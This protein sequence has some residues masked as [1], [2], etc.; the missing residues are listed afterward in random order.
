MSKKENK[1]RLKNVEFSINKNDADKSD[2]KTQFAGGSEIMK[3]YV[4]SLFNNDE[5]A[6][7]DI[8]SNANENTKHFR[9]S[10][11]EI[12]KIKQLDNKSFSP[13]S[14]RILTTKNSNIKAKIGL[15]G[16]RQIKRIDGVRYSLFAIITQVDDYPWQLKDARW[17]RI[18]TDIEQAGKL[19]SKE[20]VESA[21]EIAKIV[22]PDEKISSK[23]KEDLEKEFIRINEATFD[24][25]K[26]EDSSGSDSTLY[27]YKISPANESIVI[28]SFLFFDA[29]RKGDLDSKDI[30]FPIGL[31]SKLE[32]I[33][34]LCNLDNIEIE[35]IYSS[36]SFAIVITK[37]VQRNDNLPYQLGFTFL[38]S[39]G[40]WLFNDTDWISA[41]NRQKIIFR[42]SRE[43]LV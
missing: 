23:D 33:S 5:N 18:G 22:K 4:E 13:A 21:V 24:F 43:Y 3:T 30:T 19:L 31:K 42:M 1:F 40:R 17:Y 34:E 26:N 37:G 29:L 27:G 16:A 12:D 32:K 36:Q 38:C 41:E 6:I 28:Y 7:S 8:T 39:S 2:I 9:L 25:L 10:F 20:L 14:W 11:N 35:E 15:F